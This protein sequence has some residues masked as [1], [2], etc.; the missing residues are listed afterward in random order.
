MPIIQLTTHVQ[1]PQ[2]TCFDLVLNVDVQVQLDSTTR[3]VEGVT[4]GPLHLGDCVTWRAVHFG[5]PWRMTSK[6]MEVERP[7]CFVDAMQRGPFASWRHTHRFEP[8]PT[9]TLIH[10]SVT[11]VAPLGILGTLFDAVV[12]HRYLTGLLA[13]RNQR[14]RQLTESRTSSP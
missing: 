10:D 14:L 1:A 11:Y 7:R 4:S 3:V 2:E 13:S 6:I 5:L 8:L 12:L 9:G